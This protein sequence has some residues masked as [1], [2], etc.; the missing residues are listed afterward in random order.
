MEE[1]IYDVLDFLQFRETTDWNIKLLSNKSHVV[2]SYP[3]LKLG[4]SLRRIKEKMRVE[5]NKLYSRITIKTNNG[6]IVVRDTIYGKEIKTKQQFYISSGQLGVSKID[7][8][9]GAFGIVPKDADGAIITG[10]FWVYDVDD[11]I[12]D[13]KYLVLLFS[14]EKFVQIWK[15][16]S[17]GSGNRLYLQEKKFLRYKIPFPSLS[18]Q[19]ELVKK[20]EQ[21]MRE[22]T[23]CETKARVLEKNI[24]E[25]LLKTL[26]IEQDRGEVKRNKML[27]ITKLSKLFKW[28]V[29]FNLRAI[30]PKEI[31]QSHKYKNASLVS[32]CEINPTTKYPSNVDVV[33]FLPMEC[34]SDVYGEV[35][36]KR[37]GH[38][39]QSKGYTKFQD[40]DL[41]WA[42]ITPCMQNGK[43]A[44]ATDLVNGFGYGSTEYHV[45]RVINGKCIPEYMH[46][47]LRTSYLR[48]V[49]QIY[50]TGSA[51]QQRVG[52]DFLEAL[53]LPVLPIS[54][55]NKDEVTQT[56]I[57]SH[58]RGIKAEIKTLRQKAES[59]RSLAKKQFEEAVFGE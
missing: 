8:R 46:A 11:T 33:S 19:T 22:A 26:G 44:I 28:G 20:Y 12:A 56:S 55:S 35:I 52:L 59:L 32:F 13:I 29:E 45:F 50:F 21:T 51:G 27:N 34:I 49:A 9:N 18:E 3:L 5:D 48:E 54:S 36:E 38:A 40:S 43:C 16:C 1:I 2:S 47:M 10:N 37:K 39:S 15:E 42:K 57:C 7:A 31:F 41:L 17:N 30:P 24:E 14:S 6:G 23:A 4:I 25:Y 53:T 58:I